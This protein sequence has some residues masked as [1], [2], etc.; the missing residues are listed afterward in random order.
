MNETWEDE[1]RFKNR[2]EIEVEVEIGKRH[3]VVGNT[4]KLPF[5]LINGEIMEEKK[6]RFFVFIFL[7]FV[8]S[9]EFSE[10]KGGGNEWLVSL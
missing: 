6:E 4:N 5:E 1:L 8:E 10:E 2:I 7:G 3:F 9:G